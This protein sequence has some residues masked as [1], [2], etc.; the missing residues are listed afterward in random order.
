MPLS[1]R[2]SR[3]GHR[4]LQGL[5]YDC[6]RCPNLIPC[7]AHCRSGNPFGQTLVGLKTVTCYHE[8]CRSQ[9]TASV[10][11][12]RPAS[13]HSLEKDALWWL[14]NRINYFIEDEDKFVGYLPRNLPI[15]SRSYAPVPAFASFP[16]WYCELYWLKPWLLRWVIRLLDRG[17][18]AVSL[19]EEFNP[20][21][22]NSSVE[23][24]VF[25]ERGLA[26]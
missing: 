22:L 9:R 26:G 3:W 5:Q 19:C 25:C 16:C 1:H 10:L 12:Y 18:A 24:I 8:G 7:Q 13:S 14:L 21:D 4:W 20:G 6:M 11:S 15:S 23:L 17:V 2:W